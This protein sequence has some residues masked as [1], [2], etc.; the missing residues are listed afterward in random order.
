MA[1]PAQAQTVD[2]LADQVYTKLDPADKPVRGG[3][4]RLAVPLY[5]GNMN[6]NRWPVNDWVSL[7][8]FHEKLMVND[9]GY[10]PTV[11]YIAQSIVRERLGGDADPAQ[12]HQFHDGARALN[13]ETIQYMFE[14]IASP[15]R[16]W[17][18]GSRRSGSVG[19]RTMKVRFNSSSPGRLSRDSFGEPSVTCCQVALQQDPR[20]S[21]DRGA[22]ALNRG[23]QPR[24][25]KLKRNPNWWLAKALGRLRC[26]TSTA[27]R[28]VIRSSV[29]G[30][31]SCR[32]DRHPGLDKTCRRSTKNR[33]ACAAGQSLGR[34]PL[35]RRQRPCAHPGAQDHQPCDRPQGFNRA[36]S[37]LYPEDHW[38]HNPTLKPVSFDQKFSR[39]MLAQAGFEKGLTIRG[40]VTNTASAVQVAEAVKNMLGQV[41]INWQVD[42]LAPVAAAARREAGDYDMATGG[43]SFV[44]DPTSRWWPLSRTAASRKGRRTTRNAGPDRGGTP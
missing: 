6:P 15:K 27:S 4:L 24:A 18:I 1:R 19:W 33:C 42:A 25:H 2:R 43:W 39:D 28:S 30:Q 34:L 26:R 41:G 12:R 13:A 11:P 32:S 16:C 5:I 23:G 35:Q 3:T 7:S 22:R 36:P 20:V 8:Y 29:A 14:W 40:Y 17:T 10:M 21:I 31:F 38:A 44:L 37:E 9:G